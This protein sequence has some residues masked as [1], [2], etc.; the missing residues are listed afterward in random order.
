V[1]EIV[2]KEIRRMQNEDGFVVP[3]TPVLPKRKEI[4]SGDMED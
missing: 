4:D 2:Q 3:K 1:V